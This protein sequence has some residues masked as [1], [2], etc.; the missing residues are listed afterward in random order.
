MSSRGS[1]DVQDVCDRTLNRLKDLWGKETKSDSFSIAHRK[2]FQIQSLKTPKSSSSASPSQSSVTELNKIQENSFLYDKTISSVPSLRAKKEKPEK[3][4]GS[5]WF[6]MKPLDID[7][8]ETLKR[9]LKL[10]KLRNYLDPKR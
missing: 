9:D 4:L 1:D 3:S 10:I 6:D 5:G 7:K 8:D 2:L